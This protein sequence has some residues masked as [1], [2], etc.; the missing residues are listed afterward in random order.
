ML[1][2]FQQR[3]LANGLNGILSHSQRRMAAL[4][5]SLDALSPLKVLGRGYSIARKQDGTILT[6]VKQVGPDTRFRLRLTDGEV[7]CRTER[8]DNERG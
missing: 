7:S 6:S 8:E 3:R 2:D 5:A 1:L 4:S